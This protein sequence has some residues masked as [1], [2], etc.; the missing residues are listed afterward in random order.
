LVAYGGSGLTRSEIFSRSDS[1]SRLF[2]AVG[3]GLVHARSAVSGDSSPERDHSPGSLPVAGSGRDTGG[4]AALPT[5]PTPPLTHGRSQWAIAADLA[6]YYLALGDT[7]RAIVCGRAMKLQ[8]YRLKY[9]PWWAPM[10][11]AAEH[12]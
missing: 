6:R 3:D 9:D 11:K 7:S 8:P 1:G 4:L 10:R 5:A 2:A 12:E